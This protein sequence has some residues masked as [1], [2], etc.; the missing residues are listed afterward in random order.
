MYSPVAIE[1]APAISPATPVKMIAPCAPPPAPIPAISEALVTTPSIA[2]KT[3]GRSQP[4]LTSRCSRSS[5]ATTAT[6]RSLGR[7]TSRLPNGIQ[8]GRGRPTGA[9]AAAARPG[10]A[11]SC[12][13]PGA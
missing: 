6:A 1:N 13:G 2:P 10:R 11:R 8:E 3:A 5:P 7:R 4:P 9:G 12:A